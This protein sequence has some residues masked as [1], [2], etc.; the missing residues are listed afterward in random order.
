MEN[1]GVI[2]SHFSDVDVEEVRGFSI[3]DHPRR[4]LILQKTSEAFY[5]AKREEVLRLVREEQKTATGFLSVPR[6]VLRDVGRPFARLVLDAYHREA[7]TSSDVAEYLGAR[8]KHFSEI[9]RLVYA[10]VGIA[11]GEE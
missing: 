6:R 10:P 4:L 3:S 8:A 5:R 11:Q 9:E 7:I 1:V 2:V